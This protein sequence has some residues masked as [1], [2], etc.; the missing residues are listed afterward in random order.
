VDGISESRSCLAR[1]AHHSA[2]ET[3][4]ARLELVTRKARFEMVTRKARFEIVTRLAHHSALETRKARLDMMTTHLPG[5]LYALR[6]S[7]PAVRPAARAADFG[8]HP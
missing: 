8:L 3:R 7:R 6:Q 4:K 1:L 2:I 5:R